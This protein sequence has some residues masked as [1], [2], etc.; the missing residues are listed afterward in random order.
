MIGKKTEIK[1]G[2]IPVGCVPTVAVA[3][4]RCQYQRGWAA[5]PW[6]QIPP[7]EVEPSPPPMEADPT[8]EADPHFGGRLPL[9]R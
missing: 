6:K 5:P 9:W 1:P 7:L 8:L 3:A 4:T 2:C